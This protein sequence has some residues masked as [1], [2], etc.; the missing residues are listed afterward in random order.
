MTLGFIGEERSR[1][2]A[3][4]AVWG[5]FCGRDLREEV[6]TRA[7]QLDFDLTVHT[8]GIEAPT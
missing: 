6:A 4:E 5:G 3:P 7:K 2:T 8:S 1:A